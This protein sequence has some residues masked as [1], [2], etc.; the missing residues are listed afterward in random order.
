M[1]LGSIVF[2]QTYADKR[3]FP[4]LDLAKAA[5]TKEAVII[6]RDEHTRLCAVEAAGIEFRRLDNEGAEA[7]TLIDAKRAL[8]KTLPPI[9]ANRTEG[10]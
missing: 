3:P 8:F 6:S 7:T 2:G 9:S 10:K 5:A 4:A 1:I